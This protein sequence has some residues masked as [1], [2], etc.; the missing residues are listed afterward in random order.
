MSQTLYKIY[1]SNDYPFYFIS[2]IWGS[3]SISNK[4]MNDDYNLKA[5]PTGFFDGGYE[6]YV[7][8][9][10]NENVYR[11]L[12][13]SC[14]E[15]DVHDLDLSISFEWRD[16]LVFPPTITIDKP[17]NGLYLF[18]E[19]RR[20]LSFPLIIGAFSIEVTA[21]DNES[22]IQQVDFYINGVKRVTDEFFPYKYSN[23]QESKLIGEYTIK[24]VAIDEFGFQN[25]D[26]IP[27]WKIF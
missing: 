13:E 26:E 22:D 12:I 3:N 19:K 2:L 15:R 4:R 11:Q 6:L 5:L 25:S 23:W 27:V 10:L 8:G 16:D 24:A 14:G 17:Q 1:E 18:N 7:G 9:S 21:Y 20:N